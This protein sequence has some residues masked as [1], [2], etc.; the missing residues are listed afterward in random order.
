MGCGVH[1]HGN[2]RLRTAAADLQR[3]RTP[4]V[5]PAHREFIRARLPDHMHLSWIVNS[6]VLCRHRA[7]GRAGE[8][9]RLRSLCP[10]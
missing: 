4:T 8:R 2:H 1:H 5:T 10:A 9:R 6:A 7:T 3:M